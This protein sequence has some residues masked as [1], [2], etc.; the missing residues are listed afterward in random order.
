MDLRGAFS[1]QLPARGDDLAFIP[2]LSEEKKVEQ[3]PALVPKA[4]NP[5]RESVAS[6]TP[7]S[8]RPQYTPDDS[9]FNPFEK[10]PSSDYNKTTITIHLNQTKPQV[11]HSNTLW[12]PNAPDENEVKVFSPQME[13]LYVPS[14]KRKSSNSSLGSWAYN[15]ELDGI[16]SPRPLAEAEALPESTESDEDSPFPPKPP[17]RSS[18]TTRANICAVCLDEGC[19]V[20]MKLTP[21]NHTF[22]ASCITRWVCQNFSCPICR[23][24]IQLFLPMEIDPAKDPDY[25][26]VSILGRSKEDQLASQKAL[27]ELTALW[28]KHYLSGPRAD[29]NA[30]AHP[31]NDLFKKQQPRSGEALVQ[32]EEDTLTM[33]SLFVS[34]G[35]FYPEEA[36]EKVRQAMESNKTALE[37]EFVAEVLAAAPPEAQKP[38]RLLLSRNRKRVHRVQLPASDG[39]IPQ[40]TLS[41]SRSVEDLARLAEKTSKK[42]KLNDHHKLPLD[43]EME[44]ELPSLEDLFLIPDE[45]YSEPD[46]LA[47]CS[48]AK[49]VTVSSVNPASRSIRGILPASPVSLVLG[50]SGS[51]SLPSRILTPPGD[52]DPEHPTSHLIA[53]GLAG[54]TTFSVLQGLQAIAANGISNSA[55]SAIASRPTLAAAPSAAVYF[56]GYEQA[57]RILGITPEQGAEKPTLSL[58]AS[59]AAAATAASAVANVHNLARNPMIP[60]QFGVQ[61]GVFECAKNLLCVKRDIPASA[62]ENSKNPHSQLSGG[63]V[64]VAAAAGGVAGG[65]AAHPLN[66]IFNGNLSQVVNLDS[67]A[68]NAGRSALRSLPTCTCTAVAYHYASQLFDQKPTDTL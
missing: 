28:E 14:W 32:D 15:G 62:S 67:L 45:H 17:S 42:L 13:P 21:C 56:C 61:F 37:D 1:F 10:K 16:I 57:K 43:L 64:F 65:A 38:V 50:G 19:A 27:A 3:S 51:L 35:V 22:H 66:A 36:I 20:D 60:L 39:Q 59:Y 2:S 40:P 25:G 53:G 31:D 26:G 52:L 63:E 44:E 47:V 46:V 48:P 24:K 5:Y 7:T 11:N 18:S 33:Y 29:S 55:I 8:P 4:Y 41:P 34:L 9:Y 12:V 6:T 68:R 49:L 30:G 54:L 23:Q 58:G